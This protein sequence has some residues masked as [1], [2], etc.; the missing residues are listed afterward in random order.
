MCGRITQDIAIPQQLMSD[1]GGNHNIN[2]HNGFFS[3][4]LVS[5]GLKY[6]TSLLNI[7]IVDNKVK[8][9]RQ[10]PKVC[11]DSF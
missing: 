10:E 3:R 1:I 8:I 4:K 9:N 7:S 11:F 5:V 6:L 2:K